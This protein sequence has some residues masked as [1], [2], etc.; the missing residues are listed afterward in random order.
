[1]ISILACNNKTF[2]VT[3]K[4]IA[5]HSYSAS[6][7]Y[8]C[9]YQP[10]RARLFSVIGWAPI[11][12][13]DPNDYIQLDFETPYSICAIGTQGSA[14]HDEWVTSFKMNVSLDGKT[15]KTYQQKGINKVCFCGIKDLFHLVLAA[16]M[17]F[18]V[19]KNAKHFDIES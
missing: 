17:Q 7:I 2:D 12:N 15:W 18:Y 6:T 19:F 11:T 10:W 1:L 8:D 5:D 16:N 14:K 9:R 4:Y 13:T 3:P